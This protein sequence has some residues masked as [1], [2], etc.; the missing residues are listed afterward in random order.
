MKFGT[1]FKM[2]MVMGVLVM[3][4]M[5]LAEKMGI[6][7]GFAPPQT[8]S[9]ASVSDT[10]PNAPAVSQATDAETHNVTY[11]SDDGFWIFKK[12]VY[13][14]VKEAG[15]APTPGPTDDYYIGMSKRAMPNGNNPLKHKR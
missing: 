4:A 5:F 8:A 11:T 14:T 3:A 7:V 12:P 9:A 1:F 2:F 10:V 6:N 15:P 13:V